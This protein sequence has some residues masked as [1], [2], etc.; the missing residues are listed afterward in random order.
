MHLCCE[1]CTE[2][3]T[4]FVIKLDKESGSVTDTILTAELHCTVS[5]QPNV[6][7]QSARALNCNAEYDTVQWNVSGHLAAANAEAAL[8]LAL[9][10]GVTSRRSEKT[11]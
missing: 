8:K 4:V 7:R 9:I 3:Q 5:E 11:H 6:R 2:R 10:Y 1:C